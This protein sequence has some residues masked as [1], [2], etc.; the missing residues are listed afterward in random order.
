MLIE[1][2]VD[3]HDDAEQSPGDMLNAQ[4]RS[5]LERRI[6][7]L[8]SRQKA[9]GPFRAAGIQRT[10]AGMKNQLRSGIWSPHD[11]RPTVRSRDGA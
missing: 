3:R 11:P 1:A 4:S 8:R 7:Q 2:D 9:V 10:I 5:W 6:Q